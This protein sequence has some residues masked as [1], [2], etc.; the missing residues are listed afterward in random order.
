ML[1][2]WAKQVGFQCTFSATL[3]SRLSVGSF[4]GETFP[5]H[6]SD[7]YQTFNF[8]NGSDHGFGDSGDSTCGRSTG[9]T[10][11]KGQA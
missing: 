7:G 11:R 8:G 1:L 4:P 2:S 5:F 9:T 6:V 10:A 3:G